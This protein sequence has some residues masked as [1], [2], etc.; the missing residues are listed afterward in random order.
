[1]KKGIKI[2]Y[3]VLILFVM[4]IPMLQQIF[5]LSVSGDVLYG[6]FQPVKDT[7]LTSSTWF[8]KEYQ[9]KTDAWLNENFGFRKLLVRTSNQIDFYFNWEIKAYD[10][11]KGR[12]NF[13]FNRKF[14]NEY[15]GND[16]KGE[17][18]ID[19]VVAELKVLDQWLTKRNKKLLMCFAPCKESYFP[20]YL[21]E[22]YLLKMKNK[23]N[24]S[25]Y[26]K[27][28]EEEKI[29]I[30]DLNEHFVRNKNKAEH[31]IFNEGAI[32]WTIYGASL[33]LDTLLHRMAFE[34]GKKINQIKFPFVELSETAR[35]SDDDILKAMNIFSEVNTQVFAYPYIEYVYSQ[36]SCYKPKVMIVGDSFFYGLFNTWIPLTYFSK[37]SYFLYYFK[38]AFPFDNKKDG[39]RI[40]DLKFREELEN[41]DVVILFFSIGNLSEFPFGATKMAE[42][43]KEEK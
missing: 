30:L 25:V 41:T 12:N 4:C 8:S 29:A 7:V 14:Y 17:A 28:F 18:H 34:T 16:F 2:F 9:E 5:K 21:P 31:V 22:S 23:S 24:Y 40:E 6:Y 32:H 10:I 19:S 36:D 13:L 33:A 3:V 20:E 27:K 15:S 43:L 1:M 38:Q 37:E 11:F 26:K 42:G 35:S 39:I